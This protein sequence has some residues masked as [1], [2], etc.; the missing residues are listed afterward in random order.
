MSA[1]HSFEQFSIDDVFLFGGAP[2]APPGSTPLLVYVILLMVL[3]QL[4]TSDSMPDLRL[5]GP[6]EYPPQDF[7]V[8]KSNSHL[9]SRQ[10]AQPT[11]A[12]WSLL[13]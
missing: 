2:L 6:Y 1:F 4:T 9:T 3:S 13:R 8:Q 10:E 7:T 5:C 11:N 12:F